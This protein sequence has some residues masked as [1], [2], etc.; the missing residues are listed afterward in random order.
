MLR[1]VRAESPDAE[2][3]SDASGSWGCGAFWCSQWLQVQW[4]PGSILESTSIAA[5]EFLPILLAGI[6]W[7]QAWHGCTI[8]YNC[9][10]EAVVQ[11]I[12]GRYARDPLLAHML[13]CLFFICARHQFTLVAKLITGKNNEAADAISRNNLPLFYSQVPNVMGSPTP[14]PPLAV[15]V[16]ACNQVDWLS[17]DWTSSFNFILSRH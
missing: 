17:K 9:D 3:W 4:T 16:L 13:R 1:K 7:G 2:F 15:V 10:N 11:V 12:N 5:K 8:R 6:V 14:I